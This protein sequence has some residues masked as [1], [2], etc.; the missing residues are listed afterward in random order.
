MG[1]I[2]SRDKGARFERDLANKLKEYGFNTR[3][4]CQFSQGSFGLTNADVIGIA[5]LH[6]EAKHVET[7]N[8]FKAMEQSRRDAKDGEIPVV[9]H[10]KNRTPILVTLDLE[11]FIELW[12]IKEQYESM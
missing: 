3:R 2:N 6:I 5:G 9:I 4:G 12:K 8:L 10:K 11:N 1:K 7:L